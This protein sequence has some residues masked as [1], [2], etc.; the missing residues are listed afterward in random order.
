MNHL[1]ISR[2]KP[3][4]YIPRASIN[5]SLTYKEVEQTEY[6]YSK[7]TNSRELVRGSSAGQ[8]P[9]APVDGLPLVDGLAGVQQNVQHWPQ[10]L[11]CPASAVRV[12]VRSCSS[13]PFLH[14]HL[15]RRI[16]H[17]DAPYTAQYI[18]KHYTRKSH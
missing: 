11:R 2:A 5:S 15:C 3:S 4:T 10:V 16:R 14:Q 17:F 6:S 1:Q 7:L 12:Y 18:H 8:Q 9:A 13:L